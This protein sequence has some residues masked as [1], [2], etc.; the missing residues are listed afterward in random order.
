MVLALLFVS[1]GE[2]VGVLGGW[3]VGLLVGWAG[4][5]VDG[6]LPACTFP[7]CYSLLASRTR[8]WVVPLAPRWPSY[9]GS[10]AMVMGG[11]TRESYVTEKQNKNKSV[12]G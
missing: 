11:V 3:V 10:G 6:A 9:G 8:C 2:K 12:R 7:P 5:E 1:E 4:G